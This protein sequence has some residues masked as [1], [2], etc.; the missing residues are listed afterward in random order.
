MLR[1]DIALMLDTFSKCIYGLQVVVAGIA[2]HALAGT[3]YGRAGHHHPRCPD[4]SL[5]HRR[6]LE[7]IH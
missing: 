2:G 6:S 1:Q 7:L 5:A 3:A 4:S